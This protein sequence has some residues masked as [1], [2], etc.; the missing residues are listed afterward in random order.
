V[1]TVSTMRDTEH[2]TEVGGGRR[3]HH[4]GVTRAREPS[5][6]R[7]DDVPA[8]AVT[9]RLP[10]GQ[11]LAHD[12]RVMHYGRPPT[13][14]PETWD[15]QVL[16]ATVDGGATRWGYDDFMALPQVDVRADF[17]CVTKFSML[18][19][20]WTGVLA[21]TVLAAAPPDPAATHVLVWAD[22]GYTA[23]LA[24]ADLLEPSSVLAHSNDGASLSVE[25]GWPLRL[26]VP[27]RYAWKGP[28][29]VRGFEYLTAD[30]R[31]FWEE[32]G[33]HTVGD[34]WLEQR[35]SYQE[36]DPDGT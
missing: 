15:F 33:Y 24:I 4:G 34:P 1:D 22:R 32:R 17:H 27:H 29:W 20:T 19:M 14:R 13:F 25:H 26:V 31:G 28:K 18:D 10:P 30:R 5:R 35:Y 23:N 11:E 7:S 9:T 6:E 8:T 2:P 21:A 16:G 3:S 36:L 12:W